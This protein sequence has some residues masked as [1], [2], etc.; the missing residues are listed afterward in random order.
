MKNNFKKYLILLLASCGILNAMEYKEDYYA[1]LNLSQNAS[2]IEITESLNNLYK[3][4]YPKIVIKE[5]RES[6]QN[7]FFRKS[8][9]AYM[10]LS[11][12]EL[13]EA[14]DQNSACFNEEPFQYY[15]LLNVPLEIP[16]NK[17]NNNKTPPA[18]LDEKNVYDLFTSIQPKTISE[19]LHNCG[20]DAELY[21]YDLL[22]DNALR[23]LYH[24]NPT[25]S[26]FAK[27]LDEYRKTLVPNSSYI[28]QEEKESPLSKKKSKKKIKLSHRLTLS[29]IV[30]KLKRTPSY[31]SNTGKI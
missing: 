31:R 11:N 29:G 4:A 8:V 1:L 22:S 15:S 19:A 26:K 3:A 6:A 24:Q 28:S 30:S 9:I 20:N 13:K 2:P 21:A 17:T 16:Q 7:E 10:V 5:S 27:S 14:Y 23:S 25:P 12:P 18:A